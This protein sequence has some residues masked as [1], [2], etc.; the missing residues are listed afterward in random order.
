MNNGLACDLM[1]V[2]YHL[3]D[4]NGIEFINQARM[5]LPDVPCAILTADV[6]D[7]L[8]VLC[9]QH[10]IDDVFTKPFDIEAIQHLVP[11]C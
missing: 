3:P 11:Q 10:R 8:L 6:S 9:H 1:L 4:I 2:D 7:Q 5:L